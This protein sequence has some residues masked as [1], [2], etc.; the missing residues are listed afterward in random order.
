[1]HLGMS[2]DIVELIADLFSQAWFVFNLDIISSLW[3]YDLYK[4]VDSI[5]CWTRQFI[6]FKEM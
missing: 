1:M 5:T 6:F 4:Q 2:K 3:C